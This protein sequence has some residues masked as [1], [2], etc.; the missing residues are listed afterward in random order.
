[1]RC[2]SA[3]AH[4]NNLVQERLE[5]VHRSQKELHAPK[6]IIASQDTVASE[7]QY[8][9]AETTHD[10]EVAPASTNPFIEMMFAP[11]APAVRCR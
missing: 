1:V 6:E 11:L 7:F 10:A 2:G 8:E 4:R 3:Q 9:A 5:I